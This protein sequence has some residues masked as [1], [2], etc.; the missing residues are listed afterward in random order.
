MNNYIKQTNEFK[1]KIF[2][3]LDENK[4]NY[5]KNILE[6]DLEPS[7]NVISE[8]SNSEEDANANVISLFNLALDTKFNADNLQ[9]KINEI[10]NY[11]IDIYY[12]FSKNKISREDLKSKMSSLTN[13]EFKKWFNSEFNE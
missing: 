10:E 5:N 9:Q 6:F 13:S 8:F 7:C 2:L 3:F 1:N 4:I 12:K 11:W